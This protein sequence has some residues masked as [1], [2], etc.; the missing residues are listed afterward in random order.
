MEESFKKIDEKLKSEA[1]VKE[2][3]AL[4]YEDLKRKEATKKE[5]E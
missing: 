1:G 3:A 5:D 4:K 2:L